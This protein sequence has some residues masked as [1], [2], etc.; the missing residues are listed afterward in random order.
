MKQQID[1]CLHSLMESLEG[2]WENLIVYVSSLMVVLS[3]QNMSHFLITFFKP[4]SH[5]HVYIPLETDSH[6]NEHNCLLE[7]Y[8]KE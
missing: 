8:N 6:I 2:V 1:L 3:C 5:T 7:L 4:S